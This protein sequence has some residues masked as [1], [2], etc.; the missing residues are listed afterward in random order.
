MQLKLKA[1]GGDGRTTIRMKLCGD[2]IAIRYAEK[3]L[4]DLQEMV[5]ATKGEGH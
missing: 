3:H 5:R 4:I 1:E 2:P